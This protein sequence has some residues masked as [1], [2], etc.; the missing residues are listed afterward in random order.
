MTQ[1]HVS[2]SLR[3]GAPPRPAPLVP[4]ALRFGLVGVA[5]V[6]V[7][8]LALHVLY[9]IAQLPLLVASPVAVEAAVVHNYLLND[10]WTFA[11]TEPSLARFV[12][13][14]LS[15]AMTLVVNV[16]VVWVLVGT[17]FGY[18][19]ANLTGIALGAALNF[20]ASSGWVWRSR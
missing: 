11:G 9:G 3:A 16:A 17:G 19:A 7:N 20:G 14:N 18:V 10:R 5:G 13:F 6:A 8:M 2:A 15:T 12:K 1:A 4:T